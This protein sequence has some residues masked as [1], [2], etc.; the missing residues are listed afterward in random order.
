M[1]DQAAW[2]TGKHIEVTAHALMCLD[3]IVTGAEY[4]VDMRLR[5][6]AEL[7]HWM[8]WLAN[9]PN[10]NWRDAVDAMCRAADQKGTDGS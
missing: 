3:A 9:K 6:L 10:N 7:R 1:E 5:A 4:T 8:S 2:K